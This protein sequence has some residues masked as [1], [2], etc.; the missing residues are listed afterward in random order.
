MFAQFGAS[1]GDL[2]LLHPPANTKSP[3]PQKVF[4]NH[5]WKN[6]K[7]GLEDA[8]WGSGP[9]IPPPSPVKPTVIL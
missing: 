8:G 3:P 9:T 4:F 2:Y 7:I 5:I 1:F 6:Y